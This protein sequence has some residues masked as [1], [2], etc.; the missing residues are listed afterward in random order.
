MTY[1]QAELDLLAAA[2][3]AYVRKG[4]PPNGRSV[5]PIVRVIGDAVMDS[6]RLPYINSLAFGDH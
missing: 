3:A 1:T 5:A 2:V 6:L 4:S